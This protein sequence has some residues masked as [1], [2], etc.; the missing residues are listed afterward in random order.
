MQ[1]V[2]IQEKIVE[3]LKGET[4]V[5]TSLTQ[6]EN[7]KMVDKARSLIILCLGDKVLRKVAKEKIVALM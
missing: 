6:I 2:L 5:P 4:P 7:T 3:L 1:A